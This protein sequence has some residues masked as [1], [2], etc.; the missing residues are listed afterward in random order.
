MNREVY[1]VN[2][3]DSIRKQQP[4]A[5]TYRVRIDQLDNTV[6]Y[7]L[8]FMKEGSYGIY[9]RLNVDEIK[10]AAKTLSDEHL[11]F[12]EEVKDI[13]LISTGRLG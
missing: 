5:D 1:L 11:V 4:P 7:D 8:L 13:I 3:I 6:K 9:T 12:V 10:K 2:N